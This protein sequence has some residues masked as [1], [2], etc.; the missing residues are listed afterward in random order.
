MIT[1]TPAEAGIPL[2]KTMNENISARPT[3]IPANTANPIPLE[4]TLKVHG[5][6]S[7]K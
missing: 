4:L 7:N 1:G 5:L 2:E 6:S 3:N